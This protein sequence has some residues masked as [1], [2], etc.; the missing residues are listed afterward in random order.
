MTIVQT[1]TT[2]T[3]HFPPNISS[4][5]EK[6]TNHLHH[7]FSVYDEPMCVCVH[8]HHMYDLRVPSG[9]D[10]VQAEVDACVVEGDQLSLDLQLFLKISLKLLVN[11]V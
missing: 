4:C 11:V 10:K 2:T 9:G 1:K 6:Q 8:L 7:Q 5:S 3:H